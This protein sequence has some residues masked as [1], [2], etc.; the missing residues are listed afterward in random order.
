MRAYSGIALTGLLILGPTIA[1]AQICP[2]PPTSINPRISGAVTYDSNARIYTYRYTVRNG[3]DSLI[4]I[5]YVALPLTAEPLNILSAKGWSSRN[6]ALSQ[7]QA[8]LRWATL[9]SSDP[10]ADQVGGTTLPTPDFAIAPGRAATGFSFQS[11]QP[12]GIQQFFVEGFTQIPAGGPA[13]DTDDEPVPQCAGWDFSSPRLSTLVTGA[14]VGPATPNVIS[15]RIRL[16]RSDDGR[17]PHGQVDPTQRGTIALLVRTTDS[18]D[19][20]TIAVSTVRFG[21][22]QAAPVSSSLVPR[23]ADDKDDSEGHEAWEVAAG[24]DKAPAAQRA[25]LLLLFNLAD[26]DVQCVL[27]KSLFLTGATQSAASILGAVSPR[28]AGCRPQSPGVRRT[29]DSH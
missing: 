8:L 4:P 1:T 2:L 21:P 10:V 26:L 28:F 22:G 3:S 9:I 15:V 5:N 7:T 27:D 14:T 13:T 18:F 24:D 11:T 17:R 29:H 20:S 25:D 16:R 12:P 19:A 6:I 23:D